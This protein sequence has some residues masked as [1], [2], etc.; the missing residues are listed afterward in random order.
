MVALIECGLCYTR[1]LC[2]MP[3]PPEGSLHLHGC[4]RAQIMLVGL[5]LMSKVMNL[6]DGNTC[7]VRFVYEDVVRLQKVACAS[8]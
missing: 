2:I 4:N 5:S 8:C 7:R 6:N 3:S 1:C